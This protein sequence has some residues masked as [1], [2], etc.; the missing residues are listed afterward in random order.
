[1]GI[2]EKF[3][4]LEKKKEKALILYISCG[5]PSADETIRIAKEVIDAGCDILELGL[6]FSDPLADGPTIQAA[7]QRALEKGMNTD[8]YFEV[9]KKIEGVPK[10]CMTYYNLLLQ[11]G[12]EKFCKKSKESGISGFIIP[13][14]PLEESQ[15]LLAVCK[16]NGIDLI[17]IV[18]PRTDEKRIEKIAGLSRGFLYLQSTLGVTGARSSLPEELKRKI[19]QVKKISKIPV[20]VGFGVSKSE[21]VR[22]IAKAGADGIIIGSALIK[23]IQDG[24]D[25]GSFVRGLKEATR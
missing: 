5:D 8:R 11:Y 22:E 10:V 19:E 14:L 13:D 1:M 17:S 6:P 3:R 23:G 25:V 18:S 20:A 21:Q 2:S 24:R 12:L 9:A 15:D 7:S 16:K 4:E